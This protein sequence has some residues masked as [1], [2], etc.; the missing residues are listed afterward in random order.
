I[1]KMRIW[2]VYFSMAFL[3]LCFHTKK[4]ATATSLFKAR[5]ISSV[6]FNKT[7]FLR[8]LEQIVKLLQ[9]KWGS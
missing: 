7:S 6:I 1:K 2:R 3:L 4:A 8:K 9:T 5:P